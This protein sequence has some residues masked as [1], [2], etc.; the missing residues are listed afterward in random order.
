MLSILPFIDGQ[1]MLIK[2]IYKGKDGQDVEKL[3]ACR[4]FL[5]VIFKLKMH[6]TVAR[7]C[8]LQNR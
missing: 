3:I 2:K 7:T 4:A 5:S 1:Y 6:S 8:A